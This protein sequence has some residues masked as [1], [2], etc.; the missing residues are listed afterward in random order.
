MLE[1]AKKACNKQQILAV[2]SPSCTVI[3]AYSKNSTPLTAA[4]LG[5]SK[6]TCIDPVL[7]I[8]SPWKENGNYEYQILY[9][10]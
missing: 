7:P 5:I 4:R 3:K 2:H 9:R 1:E 8:S 6:N 10:L